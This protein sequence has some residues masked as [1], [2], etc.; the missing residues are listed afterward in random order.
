M[1]GART[2]GATLR[3]IPSRRIGNLRDPDALPHASTRRFFAAENRVIC[4]SNGGTHLVCA[5]ERGA[6]DGT[7]L[8]ELLAD[9]L[10]RNPHLVS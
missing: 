4:D 2:M 5:I 7:A 6:W 10:N 1:P 8:A 3:T 9:A